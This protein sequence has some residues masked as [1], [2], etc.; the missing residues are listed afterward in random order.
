MRGPAFA[1]GARTHR[2]IVDVIERRDAEA[3]ETLWR[4]HIRETAAR[5][6]A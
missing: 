6:R 2:R 3:A 4:R 5:I 1:A